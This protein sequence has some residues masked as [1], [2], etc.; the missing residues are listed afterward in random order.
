[1]EKDWQDQK[2]NC[3][4]VKDLSRFG[5][6][7]IDVGNYL[8][9]IFPQQDIRFIAVNDHYDSTQHDT[10]DPLIIP[11]KNVF[12][13]YY[14]KDIQKRVNISLETHRRNGDFMGAF[15]SYGYLKEPQDKHQLIID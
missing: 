13:G 2:I 7:Y 12:N 14:A 4:I 8:D 6:T 9:R 3:I 11:V 15:A 5:R 10:C 1:M